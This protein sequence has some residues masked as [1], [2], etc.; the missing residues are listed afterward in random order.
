MAATWQ[1]GI[2]FAAGL[3]VGVAAGV[4]A[5]M[6]W[7]EG[8]GP[9]FVQSTRSMGAGPVPGA[10]AAADECRASPLLGKKGGEDGQIAL[11]AKAAGASATEV[12]SLILRGKEAAAAGRQRDAEVAF[13][14][15]CRN[16]ALLQGDAV[17]LADSMYQLA[18]H[19]ATT[20]AFGAQPQKELYERAERLYSAA[21][22]TY[23]G[24]Y[25][26][27][28]EKT[29]F[30]QEGL[31]T[32]QQV[33]GRSGPVAP[34]AKAPPPP[35]P[36]EAAPVVQA[37][38]A[39][40]A[41]APAAAPTEIAKVPPAPATEAAKPPEPAQTAKVTPPRPAPKAPARAKPEP[42]EAAPARVESASPAPEASAPPVVAEPRRVE[43]R[44][45]RPRPEPVEIERSPEP[46]PV[47][48]RE[49][50]PPRR[51]TQPEPVEVQSAPPATAS[52]SV[53]EPE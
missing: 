32:V 47:R 33:T 18:R 38:P 50:E 35:A 30:A 40:P 4:A 12:S 2:L 37:P 45:P 29:R 13:L 10:M 51:A 14:N 27:G 11:Q 8:P 28:H 3:A 53:G 44:R 39:Q 25:G 49:P 7:D 6:S 36:A 19:Y 48:T 34:V 42:V 16:A 46:P 21:L 20:A 15:A 26:A 24:R 1:K 9:E 41:P 23:S 22:G 52:G 17:P 31:K 5:V 43:P